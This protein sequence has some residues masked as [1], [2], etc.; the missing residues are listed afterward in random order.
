MSMGTW[1]KKKIAKNMRGSQTPGRAKAESCQADV[2]KK[3]M[4]RRSRSY[5]HPLY[6]QWCARMDSLNSGT[7]ASEQ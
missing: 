6:G 7:R 4:A 3:F 1:K 2:M 5:K